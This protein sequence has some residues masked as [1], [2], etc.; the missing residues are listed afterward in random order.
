MIDELRLDARRLFP[1][2]VLV[3]AAH[4][5]EHVAQLIQQQA[6][7]NACPIHCRGALGFVFD[8]EWVH[9]AYN[10]TILLALAGL[11]FF[12][13]NVWLI[14]AAAVQAYHELE[15][16]IKLDQW[17]ASGHKSPQP[18]ILGSEIDLIQLHFGFNTLVFLLVLCGFFQLVT[19]PRAAAVVLVVLLAAPV[20]VAYATRTPTTAL[21]A[22]VH[23]G[24]LIVDRTQAL[25][26]E[27]GA[28]VRGGIRITADGVT[29]R[30]I[31]VLGG[32]NGIEVDGAVGVLLDRVE[33]VGAAVDGINVRRS[34]VQIRD[35]TVTGLRSA[36]AQGIDLSFS[37]DLGPSRVDRCTIVGGQEGIVSHFARVLVH[38]NSIRGA[39]MRGITVT[40]MSM[41]RVKGNV[42]ESV[43]GV[44]I[45]CGDYS[46]CEITENTVRGT[47]PQR[48]TD[49]RMRH[50]YAIQSHFGA[51]ARVE[52]NR[53]D[54]NTR[55]IAAFAG[56]EIDS[57]S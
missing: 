43:F 19:R 44:G 42:V 40:E 48:G 20:G 3:M 4:E 18:G 24:P 39:T 55:G 6:F 54:R 41:G 56:A 47:R 29:I 22:G 17:F 23:D 27:P 16:V 15:H 7:E 36:Y 46:S 10:T 9:F 30:G 52:G 35:C 33:V 57:E 11:A 32:E 5:A 21:A 51:S 14:A 38:G 31:R 8:V 28:V 34:S 1:I 26:G 53:L 37:F 25:I 12:L 50:G 49:D 2:V 13:R 45:F